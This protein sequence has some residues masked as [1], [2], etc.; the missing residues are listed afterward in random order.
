MVALIN[1]TY[2]FVQLNALQ[3]AI[4]LINKIIKPKAAII[5]YDGW[6]GRGGK[7]L[8]RRTNISATFITLSS[9]IT[10][11]RWLL[12]KFVNRGFFVNHDIMKVNEILFVN[13]LTM[14]K[15]RCNEKLKYGL[16]FPIYDPMGGGGVA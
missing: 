12:K 3:I 8:R 15:E 13:L 5:P 16:F 4:F 9:R 6:T 11:S 1:G 2:L 10:K 7:V 14:V